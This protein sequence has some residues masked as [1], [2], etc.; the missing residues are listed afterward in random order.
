MIQ[1]HGAAFK[2]SVQSTESPWLG[3]GTTGQVLDNQALAALAEL[4]LGRGRLWSAQDGQCPWAVVPGA[5]SASSFVVGAVR[6]QCPALWAVHPSSVLP[7][8]VRGVCWEGWVFM[9]PGTVHPWGV[10]QGCV[11]MAPGTVHPW[12]V[13]PGAVCSWCV[14]PGLYEH[15]SRAVHPL[16]VVGA[17]LYMNF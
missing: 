7:G 5:L 8:N 13:V 15:G 3:P 16:E 2:I 6:A 12:C 11:S 17:G 1:N 4:L 14:E 10:I 9:A